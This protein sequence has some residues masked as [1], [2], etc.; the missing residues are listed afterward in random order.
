MLQDIRK[1]Y[2]KWLHFIL[3]F[4]LVF[5]FYFM[6]EIFW[7]AFN[8]SHAITFMVCIELTQIDAFGIKGRVV[9]TILDLFVDGLGITLAL[10]LYNIFL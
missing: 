6:G 5:I 7:D 10:L 2:D 4:A 9:D 8:F 1:K 3:A